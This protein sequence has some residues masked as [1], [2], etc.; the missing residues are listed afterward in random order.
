MPRTHAVAGERRHEILHEPRH[1]RHDR[2]LMRDGFEQLPARMIEGGRHDES[3]RFGGKAERLV[4]TGQQ[5]RIEAGGKGRTR[6]IDQCADGLE[7]EPAQGGAGFAIDAQGFDGQGRKC[8]L[9]FARHA[10]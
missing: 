9:L 3:E 6:T 1:D 4:E 7:A 8:L 2:I 5:L 10:G